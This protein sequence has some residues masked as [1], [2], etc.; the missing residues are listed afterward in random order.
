GG[1]AVPFDRR[2]SGIAQSGRRLPAAP[3]RALARS[4][5]R[6]PALRRREG[7]ALPPSADLLES[8]AA[9]LLVSGSRVPGLRARHPLRRRDAAA[10]SAPGRALLPARPRRDPRRRMAA[11]LALPRLLS[12]QPD[13]PGAVV[14]P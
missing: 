12:A 11:D 7:S 9:A 1:V 10:L 8:R 14:G 2:P 5:S 13:R 3:V 6:N 4:R